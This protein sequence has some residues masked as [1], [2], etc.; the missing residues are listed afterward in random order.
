MAL[1]SLNEITKE[2]NEHGIGLNQKVSFSDWPNRRVRG[3]EVALLK[4]SVNTQ[5]FLPA[6]SNQP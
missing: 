2:N 1:Q 6:R 5:D 4:D 3:R